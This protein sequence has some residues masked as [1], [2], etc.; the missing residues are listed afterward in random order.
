MKKFAISLQ[1][2]KKDEKGARDNE[3]Y[4][5]GSQGRN[6]D[7]CRRT[8]IILCSRRLVPCRFVSFVGTYGTRSFQ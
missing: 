2:V 3:E 4:D 5:G 7:R 8:L 6:Y 1:A